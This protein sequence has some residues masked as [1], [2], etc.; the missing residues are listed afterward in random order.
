MN[1]DVFWA[2]VDRSGD[3]WIWKGA[4]AKTG[5]GAVGYQYKNWSAHRLAWFFV[6]GEIPDNLFVCHRCDNRLCV[7]PAHLWLDTPKNNSQDMVNKGR[8]ARGEHSPSRQHPERL[9]R[10]TEHWSIKYPERTRK[11][12]KHHKAKLTEQMVKDIR[13]R[14]NRGESPQAIANE[15]DMHFSSIYLLVNRKTWSHVK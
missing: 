13:D 10:G 12:S 15:L 8:S 5:Y 4:V 11:G 9:A 14:V 1:P 7:N 2:R 6:H 3:C